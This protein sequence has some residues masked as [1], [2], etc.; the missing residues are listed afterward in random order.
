MEMVWLYIPKK[1]QGQSKRAE[2]RSVVVGG[3]TLHAPC[4]MSEVVAGGRVL[5]RPRPTSELVAGSL[6]LHCHAPH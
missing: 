3:H 5:R 6:V 2:N 4:L 1:K